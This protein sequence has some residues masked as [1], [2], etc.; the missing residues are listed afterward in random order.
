[1][2]WYL[3]GNPHFLRYIRKS[4]IFTWKWS[5]FNEMNKI[6]LEAKS[7][8]TKKKLPEAEKILENLVRKNVSH[9]DLF[10]LLG[11]TKRLL[12]FFLNFCFYHKNYFLFRRTIWKIG[13]NAPQKHEFRNAFAFLLLFL[14]F[15]LY[16]AQEL[17]TS[18]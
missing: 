15:S 16:G 11:E 8:I 17:P 10:Y 7:L 4:A 2:E 14:G 3:I 9:A 18:N 13:R 5:F 1:M 6:L 12:G